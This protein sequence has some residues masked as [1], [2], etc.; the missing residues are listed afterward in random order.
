MSLDFQE[1]TA[2]AAYDFGALR[3]GVGVYYSWDYFQ[4]GRSTYSYANLRVPF[5]TVQGFQLTGSAAVGH[6]DFSNG[7]I[8]DYEDMDV[9]LIARRGSWQ[10]S[11]GYSDTNVRAS[12]SGLLTRGKTGARARAEVLVMF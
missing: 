4:G 3:T 5:G 9:R 7:A 8:G 11:V 10:Y 1:V 6:Y 2:A 12:T